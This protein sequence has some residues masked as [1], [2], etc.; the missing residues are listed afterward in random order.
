MTALAG[1][2]DAALPVTGMRNGVMNGTCNRDGVAVV[3]MAW[4]HRWMT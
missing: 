4:I 2:P 1:R 3:P